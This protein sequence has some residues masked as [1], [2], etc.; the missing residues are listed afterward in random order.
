MFLLTRF[1]LWEA[2]REGLAPRTG[3]VASH[4]EYRRP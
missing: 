3:Y 1:N 2:E 4:V